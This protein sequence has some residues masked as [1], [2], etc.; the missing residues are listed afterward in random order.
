M[1]TSDIRRQRLQGEHGGISCAGKYIDEDHGS[2][3]CNHELL[4]VPLILAWA[5]SIHKSQGQTL[6]RVRVDL[7]ESFEKGQGTLIWSK[8]S[9]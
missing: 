1:R 8:P 4:Q 6:P 2:N 5:L 9:D 3:V 7:G